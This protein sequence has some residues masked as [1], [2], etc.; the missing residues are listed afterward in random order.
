MMF[1]AP[2][3]PTINSTLAEV[4]AYIRKGRLTTMTRE[5]LCQFE[6][7]EMWYKSLDKA[8]CEFAD[9]WIINSI[10]GGPIGI[11]KAIM[12]NNE[13]SSIKQYLKVNGPVWREFACCI[14]ALRKVKPKINVFPVRSTED[15]LKSV[16][17]R[18]DYYISN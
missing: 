9:T 2:D 17:E 3:K 1:E 13:K 18:I 10:Y 4:L 12:I 14:M 6:S 16:Q 11:G 15:S 5:N 8:Q 7:F